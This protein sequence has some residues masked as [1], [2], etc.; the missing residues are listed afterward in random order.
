MLFPVL[1]QHSLAVVTTASSMCHPNVVACLGYDV[2]KLSVQQHS[3]MLGSTSTGAAWRL[4]MV[5][6]YC[7]SG[8]VL[9][10]IKAFMQATHGRN[11]PDAAASQE[12]A[13]THGSAA[14]AESARQADALVLAWQ[15]AAGM[16]YM[17]ACDVVSGH[18]G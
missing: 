2:H 6:E 14:T 18:A 10:Y 12:H 15:V 5:L 1:P 7:D 3:S 16:A 17:H 13:V 8:T 9:E 11:E 4:Y